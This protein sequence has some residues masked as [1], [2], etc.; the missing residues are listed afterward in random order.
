MK[1]RK[2]IVSGIFLILFMCMFSFVTYAEETDGFI[3]NAEDG[4][5]VISGYNGAGGDVIV[6]SELE[7][8]KVS[9]IGNGAFFGVD[10]IRTVTVSDGIS[11][12]DESAFSGVSAT[13]IILPD[14]LVSIGDYAFENTEELESIVLPDSVTTLGDGIF[15]NSGIK[16]I[17]LPCELKC[18]PDNTFNNSSLTEITIPDSVIS[19]GSSA[20]ECC[21]LSSIT[22][23]ASV[24]D[25][26]KSAFY[27]C[28]LIDVSVHENNKNYSSD[29]N[30]VLFNK[31]KTTLIQ[32]P[33]RN[34][35]TTYVIPNTVTSIERY[36]FLYAGRLKSVTIP[37]NMTVIGKSAFEGCGIENVTIPDSV[38]TICEKAFFTCENLKTVTIGEGLEKIEHDA[39]SECYS[40]SDVYYNGNEIDWEC[41]NIAYSNTCLTN[42]IVHFSEPTPHSHFYV[43]EITKATLTNN[44]TIKRKCSCGAV[45]TEKTIYS[46]KSFKLSATEY[47]YNKKTKTPTVTV[48]DSKGNTLKKDTDYTV[49][50]E[51]GR[52]Y[53]G[54]Y[55]VKITFKGKYDGV[56]RLY[57]TIAPRVT[58]KITATQT[59][60][61]I[62]LKWEKVTGAEAYRIYKYNTKK[63]AYEKL[64]DVTSTS[65][66]ISKLSAGTA[67]K[68]KVRAITKDD[69]SIYGESSAAFETATKC[70]TPSI[71]KLIASKGKA[72]FTWSNVSGESGFQVY[73][74]AKKGSGYKKVASYKANVLKGSKS[75]LTKGKTYYFKVRAYKKTDSGT[76]F[77]AWSPVKS[78]KVK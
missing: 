41:I 58:K 54:K 77:S 68:Y 25:I 3:Y 61:T 29:E 16:K 76:V 10:T 37:N 28:N 31:D 26:G 18:I 44:G 71:T 69:G 78:I 24:S 34:T 30:G 60:S 43:S 14:S 40:I 72:S 20:F 38:T 9:R 27:A 4:C 66:K 17:T 73:Y 74:S 33:I 12:I 13:Q 21:A 48:K 23:P 11:H 70:K 36:A 42:A 64:K 57:F 49:S 5:A 8:Y 50:Y 47:T 63:K 7:G 35:R 46:P 52:K 51:S 65:L 55:T 2:L 75:K 1:K 45:E 56:K 67:Y 22:I 19:I 32:Y 15:W 62:T 53:P 59:T 6:P 39:F